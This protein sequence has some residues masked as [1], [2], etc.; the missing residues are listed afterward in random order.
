MQA[1]LLGDGDAFPCQL[2]L[3]VVTLVHYGVINCAERGNHLRK[4]LQLVVVLQTVSHIWRKVGQEDLRFRILE[5]MCCSAFDEITVV[6][7]SL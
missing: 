1:S 2:G 7:A 6:E 5:L 3:P 4:G